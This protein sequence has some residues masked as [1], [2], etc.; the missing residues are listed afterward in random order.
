M[1]SQVIIE[2]SNKEWLIYHNFDKNYSY[3]ISREFVVPGY[4]FL[5]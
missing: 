1:N 4:I 2:S 5:N 3:S